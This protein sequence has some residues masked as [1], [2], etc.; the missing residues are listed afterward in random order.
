[1]LLSKPTIIAEAQ[2]QITTQNINT[3]GFMQFGIKLTRLSEDEQRLLASPLF[4]HA[5]L[6]TSAMNTF[7]NN[8]TT[9][10]RYGWPQL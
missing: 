4:D 10:T 2:S 1:L 7:I 6:S 8:N 5:A 9:E 3:M